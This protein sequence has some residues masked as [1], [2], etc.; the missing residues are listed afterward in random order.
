MANHVRGL[1]EQLDDYKKFAEERPSLLHR[2][3]A[4]L[5]SQRKS[6]ET[7]SSL[8]TQLRAS[9][10][11]ARVALRELEE[12]KIRELR[13]TDQLETSLKNSSRAEE[14]KKRHLAVLLRSLTDIR[15]ELVQQKA[16]VETVKSEV[17][18]KLS[19]FKTENIASARAQIINHI[20]V[21]CK[22]QTNELLAAAN[23]RA[24]AE[25]EVVRKELTGVKAALKESLQHN[26]ELV[27]KLQAHRQE[28]IGELNAQKAHTDTLRTTLMNLEQQLTSSNAHILDL[29]SERDHLIATRRE[30]ETRFQQ[31]R[32]EVKQDVA[33]ME[34]HVH[35]I[36][37]KLAEKEQ[38]LHNLST[39]V[40]E[41]RR[42]SESGTTALSNMNRAMAVKDEQIMVFE[43]TI[44]ELNA[45]M[46]NMRA[47]RQKTI[48]AHQSRIKQL[49]DKF[50]E[51]ITNAGRMEADRRESEVR[52]VLEKEKE[53]ALREARR[54]GETTLEQTRLAFQRQMDALSVAKTQVE[55]N[56]DRR[57]G[58]VE[59]E[60]GRKYAM[61][62]E[63]L[64]KMK[65]STEA[66]YAHYQSQIRSLEE[67]LAKASAAPPPSTPPSEHVAL[68]A[69]K[70]AEIKFLKETIRLEFG[71]LETRR[72][73]AADAATSPATT[74]T[75]SAATATKSKL[76]NTNTSPP[77][78]IQFPKTIFPPITRPTCASIRSDAPRRGGKEGATND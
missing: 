34:Q 61:L 18:E 75:T 49:Q 17:R 50:M 1:E 24:Q 14:R 35:A 15:S 69:K 67:Q 60:W 52:Q 10:E 74:T 39:K 71:G 45:A 25:V 11:E 76:H 38:E 62:N 5:E 33:L 6:S 13:L 57:I 42:N 54:L 20:N 46:Q 9:Q 40:R 3:E 63:Q 41:E 16:G 30:L 77:P 66:D 59:E 37:Q 58:A 78:H 26:N 19:A 28:A 44:R 53:D 27:Q 22:Q 36:E 29:S 65:G 21:V 12:L 68:V 48:E 4:M 32:E 73:A 7:A 51:D 47:E 64:K 72:R 56:A 70:D 23:Q 31:Q 55:M 2:I 43:R 8:Q